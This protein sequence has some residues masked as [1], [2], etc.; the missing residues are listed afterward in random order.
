MK[1]ISCLSFK[2]TYSRKNVIQITTKTIYIRIGRSKPLDTMTKAIYVT[3]LNLFDGI[4]R[5]HGRRVR[6]EK[7]S[8]HQMTMKKR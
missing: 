8:V 4:E 6:M 7:G 1:T 3:G 5:I 2:I